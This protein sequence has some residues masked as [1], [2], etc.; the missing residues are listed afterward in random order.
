MNPT[1]G[2]IW[3]DKAAKRIHG[4]CQS[5]GWHSS[6]SYP[7]ADSTMSRTAQYEIEIIDRVGNRAVV[8]WTY[9]SF[10]DDYGRELPIN[11]ATFDELLAPFSLLG[12]LKPSKR[13]LSLSL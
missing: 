11:A 12:R 9:Q 6:G 7:I 4:Y 10:L 3:R 1:H 2:E 8:A 13:Q 5:R